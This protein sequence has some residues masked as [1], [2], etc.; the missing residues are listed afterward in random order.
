MRVGWMVIKKGGW[1][2]FP[3]LLTTNNKTSGNKKGSKKYEK[4]YFCYC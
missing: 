2:V 1:S 4:I 3:S